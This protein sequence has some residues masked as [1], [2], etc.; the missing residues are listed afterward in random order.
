[1]LHGCHGYHG[2]FPGRQVEYPALRCCHGDQP[3][4]IQQE[5]NEEKEEEEEEVG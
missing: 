3:R 2:W 5:E 1:M 4:V